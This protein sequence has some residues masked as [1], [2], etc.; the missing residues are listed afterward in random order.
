MVWLG[1]RFFPG[2]GALAEDAGT[3][4][5]LEAWAWDAGFFIAGALLGGIVGRL[6]IKPVNAGLSVIFKGFNRIFDRLTALYGWVIGRFLRLSAIVLLVYG[7]L[8][9][10]TYL[11]MVRSPTGFIPN[12]DQGYVLLNVQLPDSASVQRT[13]EVMYKVEEIV[14]ATKGVIHTVSISGTSFLLSANGSNFG[15][16]FI[17][18]DSY[19]KRRSHETYDAT[20]AQEIQKQCYLQ[21][22]DAVI[23]VFRAPPIRGLGN[24]G[25]FKLQTEQRGF[26]DLDELQKSTDELVQAANQD[27]RIAG[28]FTLFRANTP[29]I[30]LDIDRTKAQA[31]QVP[32]QDLFSTLQIYMGGQYI[33]DFNKFGRTWQVQVQADA[34]FRANA[35]IIKQLK[36][37]NLQ[38]LMVPLG[39]LVRVENIAGPVMVMRYNMYTSAAVNGSP[40]PGVS[41]GVVIQIM[42]SLAEELG[43]S[44]EWTEITYLE[45]KAGN[46]G[47][48][49]FGLGTILVYLILAAKYE[50]WRLPLAVIL[51]VPMCLLAAVTGMFIAKLPIDIFVQIGLLVLVGLA[52]KNA[53]L[54]VEFASQLRAEGKGLFDATIDASRLRFRPIVMTSFAFIFGVVPLVLSEG[55]GAEMRQSLGTA[56]F[57]GM[58]GV[59]FFGVMLTPV[60]F[61]V[62]LQLGGRKQE[63]VEKK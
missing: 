55:A 30:Y 25:G 63:V 52:S 50:S 13:Q 4:A 22:E 7:G 59:T 8:L 12:Q 16:M 23:G 2:Q 21:I 6:I 19:E 15:S 38:G 3:V 53:I 46:V 62:L 20:I 34:P 31:L 18:L 35:D 24:A 9:V 5:K 11:G 49:I 47:L 43:I 57:S 42:E 32:I 28:A 58:L 14:H 1:H 54:I 17:I 41:S 29:Q 26:V 37:R 40:A 51:V 39:T 27:P 48:L 44:I 60:F 61:Y 33:N 10:L 56:V 36:V 45:I